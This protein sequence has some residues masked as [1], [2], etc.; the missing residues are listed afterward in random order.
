MVHL[1]HLLCQF[2]P[3]GTQ[4]L[5]IGKD[6]QGLQEQYTQIKRYAHGHFPEQGVFVPIDHRM[7]EPVRAGRYRALRSDGHGIAKQADEGG[8]AR[9]RLKTLQPEQVDHRAQAERSCA[10]RDGGQIDRNP[11]T[12]WH[13]V[14][15]VGQR[16]AF[17]QDPYAAGGA[18]RKEDR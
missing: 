2:G 11:Q 18:A 5:K 3:A 15:Q 16:Q 6:G 7:P 10:D 1:R 14:R 13:Q 8:C 17:P 12:P 9:H 4:P